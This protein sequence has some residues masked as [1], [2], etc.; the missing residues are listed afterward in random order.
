MRKILE[1]RLENAKL[2]YRYHLS[3][4]GFDEFVDTNIYKIEGQIEA[5]QDCLTLLPQPRTEAEILKDFEKLGYEV[6]CNSDGE[7]ILEERFSYWLD[8]IHISKN[9]KEYSKKQWCGN[10]ESYIQSIEFQEHKL[11]NE[12]FTLWGWL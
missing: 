8:R 7:L 12:L 5:Y 6:V 11:L 10:R 9:L 3:G 4:L 1:E 2:D